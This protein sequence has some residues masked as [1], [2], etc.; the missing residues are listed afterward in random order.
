MNSYKL[1]DSRGPHGNLPNRLSRSAD[2]LCSGQD[3]GTLKNFRAKGPQGALETLAH[4]PKTSE[5]WN[6]YEI[7]QFP[8]KGM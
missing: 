5:T 6:P 2:K 7:A 3:V 4:G 1:H 8:N